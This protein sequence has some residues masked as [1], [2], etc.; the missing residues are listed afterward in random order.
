MC[1]LRRTGRDHCRHLQPRRPL[2]CRN[3]RRENR[4]LAGVIEK[5]PKTCQCHPFPNPELTR[6]DNLPQRTRFPRISGT[7]RSKSRNAT[8]EPRDPAFLATVSGTTSFFRRARS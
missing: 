7:D 6:A 3:Q 8:R 5:L 2:P 4:L 1:L